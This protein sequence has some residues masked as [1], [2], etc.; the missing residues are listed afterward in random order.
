MLELRT[1]QLK[2]RKK[3]LIDDTEYT[4]RRLGNIE[5]LDMSQY[6]RRLST[7]SEIEKKEK[8]LTDAQIA[9]VDDISAKL[10]LLFVNLFDDGGDQTKSRALVASLSDAEIG[11]LLGEIFAEDGSKEEIKDG[12]EEA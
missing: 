6:M 3:V 11:V 7:L 2:T 9:E 8:K 5:Q 10:S 1:N 12:N 4:V